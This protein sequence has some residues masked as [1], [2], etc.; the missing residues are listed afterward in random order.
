[1]PDITTPPCDILIDIGGT[2]TVVARAETGS[3]LVRVIKRPTP[4]DDPVSVLIDMIEEVRENHPIAGIGIGVPGPF[5]RPEGMVLNPPNLSPSWQ[6]LRLRDALHAQYSCTVAVEN[7]AN[8][9][10]LA[11]A[12]F[13]AGAGESLVVYYTISTGVGTGIVYQGNLLIGR[14]DTEGGHQVLIPPHLNPP[15]CT[16]GGAGCLEALVGGRS[17]ADLHGIE[18]HAL[19]DPAI[20]HEV[21]T[22]LGLA[23]ANTTALLDPNIIIIGG[24]LVAHWDA[25]APSLQS[26]MERLIH[27]QPLPS[28]VVE[29]LGEE[30]TLLGAWCCLEGF[31]TP[32]HNP[33]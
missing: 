11:E 13:G 29:K 28:I 20:W 32:V 14:H 31:R 2:K 26:T 5:S 21:G 24:G 17:L 9:A 19:D 4:L 30:K 6:N 3:T 7:D 23:M 10:A 8:C 12:T 16:C 25:I 18:A 1:M 22:W 33:T 15:S 27:I